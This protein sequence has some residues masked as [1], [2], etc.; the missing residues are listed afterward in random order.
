MTKQAPPSSA[1]RSIRSSPP[2]AAATSRQTVRPNPRPNGLVLT[3]ES[4]SRARTSSDSPGPES[5]TRMST[6]EAAASLLGADPKRAALRHRIGRI[7]D[8]VEQRLAHATPV[9]ASLQPRRRSGCRRGCPGARA[10]VPSGRGP[11]RS[12]GRM[13]VGAASSGC[14]PPSRS[15]EDTSNSRRWTSVSRR[16]TRPD[17]RAIDAFRKQL[18]VQLQS[19]KRIADLVSEPRRHLAERRHPAA[20]RQARFVARKAQHHRVERFPQC[21]D[22]V[23]TRQLEALLSLAGGDS[24]G[25]GRKLRERPGDVAHEREQDG[26]ENRGRREHREPEPPRR[27]PGCRRGVAERRD[28]HERRVAR[29]LACIDRLVDG[30][31]LHRRFEPPRLGARPWPALGQRRRDRVA[32]LGRRGHGD[33]AG[34]I[35]QHEIR[36][37]ERCQSPQQLRGCRG[38]PP[39]ARTVAALRN[40]PSRRCSSAL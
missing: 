4:R 34:A 25:K 16:S 32:D 24:I 17:S 27:A 14:S 26:A 37:L 12:M 21:A 15:V 19:R 40:W 13:R 35:E 5:S 6:R 20:R 30:D 33:A 39:V 2:C 11:P 8:Q 36:L 18:Q 9:E 7:D 29:L 31:A 3:G 38:V 1:L 23:G 28:G 22:F 10:T